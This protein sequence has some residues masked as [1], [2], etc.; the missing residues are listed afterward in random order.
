[1]ITTESF[2]RLTIFTFLSF[3]TLP[4]APSSFH[5]DP[6]KA[7]SWICSTSLCFGAGCFIKS[8][9]AMAPHSSTLAWKILWT[10]EPGGL[11]FIGLLRVGHD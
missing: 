3:K 10:E 7:Q 1:M 8:E 4:Q 2:K 5:L 11:Q 6:T 9:K